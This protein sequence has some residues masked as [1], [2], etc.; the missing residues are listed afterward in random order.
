MTAASYTAYST[1]FCL[2]CLIFTLFGLG[3]IV[4]EERSH[5]H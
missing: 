3:L 4:S 2:C 5:A 1:R